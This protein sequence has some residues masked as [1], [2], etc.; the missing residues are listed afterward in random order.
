[1]PKGA[2][3]LLETR[4]P[5]LDPAQR[6]EVLRTTAIASG[7]PLLDDAEGYGR[8]D[9]FAAAD[10]YGALDA[11]VT[12]T[13][14]EASG[15]FN[16]LDTWRN[17][18]SGKGRLVKRGDGAL[19]LAGINT[20]AGGTLVEKGAIIADSP[21]ALGLGPVSVGQAALHVTSRDRLLL[22]GGLSLS[23]GSTLGLSLGQGTAGRIQ[24]KA[25]VALAGRL[26]VDLAD[27]FQLAAGTPIELVK[28]PSLAGTFSGVDIEGHHAR[29]DYR[30]DAVILTLDD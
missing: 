22:D 15:G 29:L 17:D 6:R 8:L 18:L 30:A 25:P 10:G 13:M 24:A 4:F 26:R 20:Y 3:I 1:V 12:V 9:L 27:G 28:A 19:V 7:A 11:D 23:A 2:E 21:S 14:E 16:A 5:Y